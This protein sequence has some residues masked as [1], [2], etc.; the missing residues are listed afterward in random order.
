MFFYP[1]IIIY[2]IDDFFKSLKHLRS[3]GY[4]ICVVLNVIVALARTI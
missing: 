2:V 3:F 1:N 4:L